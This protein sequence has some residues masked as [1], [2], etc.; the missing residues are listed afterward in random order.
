MEKN[1]LIKT[2]THTNINTHTDTKT[3]QPLFCI[4]LWTNKSPPRTELQVY[5][6]FRHQY[7]ET[8]TTLLIIFNT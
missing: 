7:D 6:F 2:H 3:A 5:F 4:L 8:A 1:Q